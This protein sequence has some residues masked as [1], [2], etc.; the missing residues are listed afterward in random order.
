M[1]YLI[2]LL[3]FLC[4]CEGIKSLTIIGRVEKVGL[5]QLSILKVPAKV[6]TG[7]DS[8]SIWAHKVEERDNSLSVVFFGP[9]SPY[10]D[11]KIHI[12]SS[13]QYSITRISNSFGHREIRYKL[14]LKLRIK[15]KII[16]GT[17]TL[18][19]RSTKLY[20]ILIGKSLLRR[21][22]LVDV[23][24]GSPLLVA[25]KERRAALYEEIIKIKENK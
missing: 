3:Y 16:N 24:K 13:N 6:D 22:F 25:E 18:A 14:K 7:A 4:Y 8:C 10:Y 15:G 5:P 9:D 12:F 11:S 2:A 17:F 19:D 23:S 20:P 1:V 21:K